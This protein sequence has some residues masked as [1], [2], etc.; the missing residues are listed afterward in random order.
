MVREDS[1]SKVFI[2]TTFITKCDKITPLTLVG[3][4]WKK[5]SQSVRIRGSFTSFKIV[6]TKCDKKLLQSVAGIT[7]W[8]K[9]LQSVTSITK[10]ENQYK[11]RRNTSVFLVILQGYTE[12]E[13]LV[14][15]SLHEWK[16]YP[17]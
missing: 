13:G 5:L 11:V 14:G 8:D 7:R 2:I 15:P 16:T 9:L 6:I 3:P 1:E 4:F 17:S 12:Q 10:C